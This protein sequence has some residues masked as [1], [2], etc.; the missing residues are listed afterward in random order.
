MNSF[1]YDEM[2]E[3]QQAYEIAVKSLAEWYDEYAHKVDETALRDL[4]W[5]NYRNHNLD[6]DSKFVQSFFGINCTADAMLSIFR[7]SRMEKKIEDIV[8]TYSLF[9]KVPI[10]FFPCEQGGINQTRSRVFG[11]RIDFTLFD[12]SKYYDESERSKCKMLGAFQKTFTS[13]WL[14][15]IGSFKQLI[16][17]YD[18]NGIFTDSEYRVIDIE[19]GQPIEDYPQSITPYKQWTETYYEKLKA[20]ILEWYK[21]KKIT[22]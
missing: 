4:L 14:D 18:V 19:T 16:D 13:K 15:G 6:P 1:N 9:S 12:I 21:L 8:S 2:Q 7:I 22:Y 10:F 3:Y 5:Q 20:K 17:L 11:D